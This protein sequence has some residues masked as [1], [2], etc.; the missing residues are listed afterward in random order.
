MKGI[1]A[2]LTGGVVLLALVL[3]AITRPLRA[4]EVRR[5]SVP[6]PAKVT[7]DAAVLARSLREDALQGR[8]AELTVENEQLAELAAR[9]FDL[10][11][12]ACR[13]QGLAVEEHVRDTELLQ[14]M[15]AA[16]VQHERGEQRM[17]HELAAREDALAALGTLA[18]HEQVQPG[19]YRPDELVQLV[20]ARQRAAA[21]RGR[22]RA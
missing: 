4:G 20:A 3:E 8:I 13:A 17:R 6:P 10:L 21:M 12:L 1:A 2:L 5:T 22:G 16:E 11:R 9:R 19:Q 18:L 7:L 14:A 15:R